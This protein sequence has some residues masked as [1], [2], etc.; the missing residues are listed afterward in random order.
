MWVSPSPPPICKGKHVQIWCEV[1]D[2]WSVKWKQIRGPANLWPS[3]SASQNHPIAAE[4]HTD[5]LRTTWHFQARIH[6]SLRHRSGPLTFCSWWYSRRSPPQLLL[7][8]STLG[9]TLGTED[10][11]RGVTV[12]MQCHQ[13]V[14]PG[15]W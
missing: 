10:Q 11:A 7:D 5:L 15:C 8:T 3:R 12:L 2:S 1:F 14:H 4:L 9:H 6:G 13:V